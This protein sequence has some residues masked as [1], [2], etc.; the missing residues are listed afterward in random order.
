MDQRRFPG[1][2]KCGHQLIDKPFANKDKV[3]HNAE[4]QAKWEENCSALESCDGPAV[5]IDS[6]TVTSIPNPNFVSELIVCHCCQNQMSSFT[7]GH[8]CKMNCYD[9]KTKSN[10]MLDCAVMLL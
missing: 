4:L 5:V 3:K 8:V 2:A 7:N 9:S 10:T 6:K 1:C